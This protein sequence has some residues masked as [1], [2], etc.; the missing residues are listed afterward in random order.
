MPGM[1]RLHLLSLPVVVLSFTLLL[2]LAI[3]PVI[4]PGTNLQE[5]AVAAR[6]I[7][8]PRDLSFVSEA[9]TQRR[10][11]E[12]AAAVQDS[13][14]YDPG[15]AVTQQTQLNSTL[16]RI[17]NILEDPSQNTP[18]LRR[19]SIDRLD[20][21][22]LSNGSK[23]L[24]QS[25]APSDFDQV[26]T[27]SRR[28][29]GSIFERS[30]SQDDIAGTR[31]QVVTFVN[32]ALN[33]ELA[34]LVAEIVRPFVAPN[35]VVDKARSDQLRAA[36][37]AGVA[38][39]QVAFAKDQVIVERD[40]IVTP[41]AREAL[42]QANILD[43]S[44]NPEVLGASALLA[45]LASLTVVAGW[46]AFRP[47][48]SVRQIVALALAV[49]A[50]VAVI[51]VYIPLILPDD[52]RHFLAYAL[53]VA[54]ASMV[55]AGFVGAELALI[56]ASLIAFLAAF[57]AVLL[58]DVTVVG[59]AGSLDVIRIAM[60]C[61]LSGAAGV[62]AVRNAERL[63]QFLVGGFVVGLTVLVT[64]L[65]TW[66]IDSNREWSDVPWIVLAAT[67]SG[68]LSAFL[69]GGRLRYARAALRRHDAA[70]APGDVAAQPAAAAYGCRT[71]RLRP[72]STA[73]SSPTS[74][75][76]APSSSAPI[77]SWRASAATTTTSASSPVPAS[78]SRTSSAAATPT[79]RS[80]PKTAPASSPT[81]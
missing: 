64:L 42:L 34:T 13:L 6:T 70:A 40:S 61:G 44:W 28:A 78:S 16:S 32:P 46:R 23:D 52:A 51:K 15:V 39:V 59:V 49:A 25:L 20:R 9:L 37:R 22:S 81:T 77:R 29:L 47:T 80:T 73:S 33:R 45:L 67:S 43:D 63:T 30:L 26:E 31:E 76:R 35:L 72:S 21:V 1:P 58:L 14:T 74:R 18:Q 8:S 7:R 65:A 4:S 50:P 27:E 3:V 17:R 12:A 11:D 41:E 66:L 71:K 48:A 75:R 55:V 54:A 56:A 79:T 62:F 5:G 24:L 57:T 60:V 38:P 10:Q 36:A 68:V 69:S 53:P 19:S 2:F